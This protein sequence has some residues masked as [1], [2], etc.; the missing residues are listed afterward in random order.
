MAMALIVGFEQGP[1]PRLAVHVAVTARYSVLTD[2][3]GARCLQIDTYGSKTRQS[4]HKSQTLRLDLKAARD[5]KRILEDTL[6]A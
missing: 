1:A 4:S 2:E 3:R 5:L 6:G